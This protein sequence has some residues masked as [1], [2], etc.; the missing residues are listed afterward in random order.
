M[1]HKGEA[2]VPAKYNK[3]PAYQP[4][5]NSN[6]DILAKLDTLINVVDSKEFKAYISQN[7]IGKSAVSYINKQSRILGGAIV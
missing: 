1:I 5:S 6:D 4:Y 3:D 7:E 2:I